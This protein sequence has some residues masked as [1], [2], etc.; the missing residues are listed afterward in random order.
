MTERE[1]AKERAEQCDYS[2]L[3]QIA[4]LSL[5]F[6]KHHGFLAVCTRIHFSY[7]GGR[8]ALPPPTRPADEIKLLVRCHACHHFFFLQLDCQPLLLLIF[9]SIAHCLRPEYPI[10]H[11]LSP[12]SCPGKLERA[13]RRPFP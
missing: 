1:K 3:N 2:E 13:K 7:W 12:S 8:I 10:P 9:S 5:P 6:I 11:I 4:F